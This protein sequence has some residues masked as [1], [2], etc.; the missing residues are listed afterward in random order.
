MLPATPAANPLLLSNTLQLSSP[1]EKRLALLI[2]PN[3]KCQP[4]SLHLDFPYQEC[5]DLK[6][7]LNQ[8][9]HFPKDDIIILFDVGNCH[10]A[11][12][13]NIIMKVE[14]MIDRSTFG[15]ELF[16]YLSGHGC[17]NE[18]FSDA[19][20]MSSDLEDLDGFYWSTV[21][22]SLPTGV[23][24]TAFVDSCHSGFLFRAVENR[25]GTVAVTSCS[26]FGRTRDGDFYFNL[27]KPVLRRSRGA[28]NRQI[29]Q[30]IIYP[31]RAMY[32]RMPQLKPRF[33]CPGEDEEAKFV[34]STALKLMIRS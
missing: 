17:L 1:R 23:S 32:R 12:K 5:V 14:E 24:L 13:Q 4:F 20:F 19:A 11:T 21:I 33:F 2:G 9:Y 8:V 30:R 29:Y 25:P 31:R 3:Y 27:L 7:I 28:T 22:E 26:R 18:N 16:L 34:N 6:R 10:S 15:D